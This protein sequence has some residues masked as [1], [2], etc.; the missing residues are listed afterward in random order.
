MKKMRYGMKYN[1][2][3]LVLVP[4]PFTDLSAAKRRPALVISPDRFNEKSEDLILVAVTSKFPPESSEIE[5]PLEKADLKEGILPKRSVVKLAKIFTMHS[6][7]IVKKAG[8]LKD[9]KIQEILERLI[10]FLTA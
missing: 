3:T 10:A 1:R 5:M 9:Q 6:G 2:G 4:F 7:L 8:S